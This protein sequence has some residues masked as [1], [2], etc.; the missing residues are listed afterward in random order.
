MPSHLEELGR[1]PLKRK[2]LYLIWC[3]I[4]FLFHFVRNIVV[5]LVELKKGLGLRLAELTR[6]AV[7]KG[8]GVREG[9]PEEA[10]EI[11][12]FSRKTAQLGRL[13]RHIAFSV[14]PPEVKTTTLDYGDC[15]GVEQ[16]SNQKSLP[17]AR[18][19]NVD[20]QA[21]AKLISWT[22]AAKI[23]LI[24]I[25]DYHGEI[26]DS[27]HELGYLLQEELVQNYLSSKKQNSAYSLSPPTVKFHNVPTING[28]SN[29]LNGVK[30]SS[31]TLHIALFSHMD[32]K[33]AIVKVAK[34]ICEESL[35]RRNSKDSRILEVNE[36]ILDS[37]LS[38]SHG[39]SESLQ[40]FP[41][42]P[43]TL[44][45][46]GKVFSTLGFLPWDI[47]LTEIHWTPALPIFQSEDLFQVLKKFS[48]CQQRH[49]T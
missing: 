48:K 14:V 15:I 16:L 1:R 37:R 42:E 44:V 18:S 5:R 24:S 11:Y 13:P 35:S 46:L 29:G 40:G 33:S 43:D 28:H 21:L 26:K 19:S 34:D 10:E 31:N 38:R 25:Y 49:G 47:R 41:S 23:P 27:H 9:V 2:L 6:A 17:K 22:W 32:G 12:T 8:H 7:G 36:S 39:F 45:I 30:I 3:L 4:H 20:M